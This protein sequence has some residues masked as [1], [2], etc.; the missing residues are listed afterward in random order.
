M[1]RCQS[2]K[3]YPVCPDTENDDVNVH[4]GEYEPMNIVESFTIPTLNLK[5]STTI[6]GE[7]LK[8]TKNILEEA[9]SITSGERQKMY[10]KPEDNFKHIAEIATAV[11]GYEITPEQIAMVHICT[12]LSR[13]MNAH[14]RDN[15]VDLAGYAW[16]LSRIKGDEDK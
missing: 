4:C 1:S 16:V 6:E 13:E 5:A 3:Q 7:G 8:T 2:C 14:K 10:G 9:N 12:K 15:L 11:F